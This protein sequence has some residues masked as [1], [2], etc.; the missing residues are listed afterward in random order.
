[1]A[2][3]ITCQA[4]LVPA[5][6]RGDIEQ[7]LLIFADDALM[8]VVTYLDNSVDEEGPRGRWFLETGYGPCS[9]AEEML[10]DTPDEAQQ[11]VLERLRKAHLAL[12]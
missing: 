6:R 8:A 5:A 9:G 12:S 1:M 7:G 2:P 3:H 4:I 11:W 10:F